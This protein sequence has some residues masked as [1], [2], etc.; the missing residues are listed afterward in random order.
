MS[1]KPPWTCDTCGQPITS[2]EDGW[3][4][5]LSRNIEGTPPQNYALRLVHTRSSSPL[6]N[7]GDRHR[8]GRHCQHDEDE[9]FARDRSTVADL[10]L[11]SFVGPDGL[12]TLLEFASE[13][14]FKLDDLIEMTKRLHIPGYDQ[15]RNSFEAAIYDGAFE[16]NTKP[17]FYLQDDIQAVLRWKKKQAADR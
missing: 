12:M 13:R 1:A 10:P 15:A 9:A 8:R 14:R 2:I 16:P 11:S 4:E 6:A 5:W 17:G 7:H 3:V